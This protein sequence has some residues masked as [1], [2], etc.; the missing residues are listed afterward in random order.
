MSL[1]A[2]RVTSA[3]A[4]WVTRD[5]ILLLWSVANFKQNSM[6][7]LKPYTDVSDVTMADLVDKGGTVTI[8]TVPVLQLGGTD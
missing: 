8:V 6:L 5:L 1:R 2:A 4:F 7:T 3:I